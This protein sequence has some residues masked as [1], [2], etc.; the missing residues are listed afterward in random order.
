MARQ[1]QYVSPKPSGKSGV[2]PDPTA[3]PMFPSLI[4][5]WDRLDGQVWFNLPEG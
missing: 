1:G 2:P 4:G 5:I 3:S